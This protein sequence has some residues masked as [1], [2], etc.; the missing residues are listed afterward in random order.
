MN[1]RTLRAMTD[2]QMWVTYEGELVLLR[3]VD[4]YLCLDRQTPVKTS[5]LGFNNE[6]PGWE[7]VRDIALGDVASIEVDTIQSAGNRFQYKLTTG[8]I[9]SNVKV[10]AVTG[11]LIVLKSGEHV[12]LTVSGQAPIQ[13]RAALGPVI[14]KVGH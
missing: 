8:L 3:A 5:K 14:A 6:G 4:G 7:R 11:I 12:L 2:A 9:N 10:P 13:V 1:S